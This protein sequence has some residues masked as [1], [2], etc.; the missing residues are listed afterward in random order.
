M[1][2]A[3]RPIMP[4]TAHG[5]ERC[6]SAARAV[7]DVDCRL[8]LWPFA[9]PGGYVAIGQWERLLGGAFASVLRA[10]ARIH[11]D[12]FVALV[13]ADPA[14]SYYLENYGFRPGFQLARGADEDE[15]WAALNYDPPGEHWPGMMIDSAKIVVVAGSS[16]SWAVWGERAWDLAI[17][18]TAIADGPWLRAGIPFVS[19][20]EALRTFTLPDR[21]SLSVDEQAVFLSNFAGFVED[22]DAP[23]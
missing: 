3:D 4:P 8:P 1:M 16:G 13:V 21:P 6:W 10:L 5:F 22:A 17:V 12:E 15:Y 19:P 7:V 23:H 18:H 11:K 2:A 9:A 20:S 14:P